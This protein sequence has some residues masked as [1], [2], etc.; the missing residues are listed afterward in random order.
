[1]VATVA[2][3]QLN[4]HRSSSALPAFEEKT[5]VYVLSKRSDGSVSESE[6]PRAPEPAVIKPDVFY[7]KYSNNDDF[8]SI[9]A[10]VQGKFRR[11]TLEKF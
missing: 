5:I 9:I 8:D 11:K 6:V 7:V 10:R 1:M 2:R 4:F 3:P